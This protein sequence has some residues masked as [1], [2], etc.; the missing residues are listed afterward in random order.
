[1]PVCPVKHL[2]AV[3]ETATSERFV[4]DPAPGLQRWGRTENQAGR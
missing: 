4:S 2:S 1:V 3:T